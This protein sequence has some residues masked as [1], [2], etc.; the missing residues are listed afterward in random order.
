M[1]G[2]GNCV[3]GFR[4]DSQ[5]MKDHPRTHFQKFYKQSKPLILRMVKTIGLQGDQ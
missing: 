5:G 4:V 3:L 1:K 2:P